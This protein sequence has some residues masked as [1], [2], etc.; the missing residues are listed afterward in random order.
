MKKIHFIIIAVVVVVA[1]LTTLCIVRWHAW[2]GKID[3]PT[4]T[5]EQTIDRLVI[6]MGENGF[7]SRTITWRCGDSLTQSEVRIKLEN[8]KDVTVIPAEGTLV[9][10]QGGSNAYY[11]AYVTLPQGYYVYQV[12]S[13]EETSPWYQMHIVENNSKCT[14]LVSGDIQDWEDNVT[15]TILHGLYRRYPSADFIA[16]LGDLIHRPLND[17]WNLWFSEMDSLSA[18]IPHLAIPGNH[19][20]TKGRKGIIDPRWQHTFA[21]P[22]NGP[23]IKQGESYYLDMPSVRL[24]MLDT[25]GLKRPKDYR[26]T[27]Q[28]IN[29]LIESNERP[30]CIV[31]MHHPVKSESLGRM[32]FM[33]RHY[34]K[35]VL[36]KTD[37]VLQGHD[38]SYARYCTKS[39]NEPTTPVYILTT[40]SEKHYLSRCSRKAD[41]VACGERLYQVVEATENQLRISTYLTNGHELYDVVLIEKDENGHP[42]ITAENSLSEEHLLMPPYFEG[43]K[44]YKVIRYNRCREL[45]EQALKHRANKK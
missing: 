17:S 29:S 34:F 43:K 23:D 21:H 16:F 1:L 5:T 18:C 28:W 14:F 38:H 42:T 30:F 12:A 24:I 41:R 39:H 32:S 9:S 3:E 35:K 36:S 11:K 31:M 44:S 33:E 22:N 2:F 25:K 20:Y 26:R 6:N 40:N 27:R 4:Y 8:T 37:A 10:T 7:N 19:E 15:D 45:R 13:G